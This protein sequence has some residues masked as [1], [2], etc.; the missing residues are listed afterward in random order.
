MKTSPSSPGF[1]SQWHEA[2]AGV[3]GNVHVLVRLG[4]IQQEKLNED[5][6]ATSARQKQSQNISII[7]FQ[8]KTRSS[9]KRETTMHLV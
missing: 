1:E 5:I 6:L 2:G 7:S 9:G 8:E 4:S 3:G